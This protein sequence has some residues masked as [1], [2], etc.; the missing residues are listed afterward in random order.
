MPKPVFISRRHHSNPSTAAALI[1][2][3]HHRGFPSPAGFLLTPQTRTMTCDMVGCPIIFNSIC[4]AI[5]SHPPCDLTFCQS[6][7]AIIHGLTPLPLRPVVRKTIG[8][9]KQ[10]LVRH[11]GVGRHHSPNLSWCPDVRCRPATLVLHHKLAKQ[12]HTLARANATLVFSAEAPCR[13]F[14][15]TCR[16]VHDARC[17]LTTR[18]TDP[19]PMTPDLKPERH[20]RVRCSRFVGPKTCL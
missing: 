2:S 18:L 15:L 16:F 9:V 5:A 3:I 8:L 20:R 1:S 10:H 14:R 13:F 17:R 7:F 19:A 6:Q 12:S 11:I 4:R